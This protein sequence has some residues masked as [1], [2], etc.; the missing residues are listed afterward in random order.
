MEKLTDLSIHHICVLNQYF[1]ALCANH[2]PKE[3]IQIILVLYHKLF[4]IKLYFKKNE[5]ILLFDNKLYDGYVCDYPNLRPVLFYL[6]PIKKVSCQYSH[7]L[8]VATTGNLYVWGK[9]REGQ[10]GLDDTSIFIGNPTKCYL[11]RYYYN[12]NNFEKV[13]N[14]KYHSMAL[15]KSGY[16]YVWGSNAQGQLGRIYLSQRPAQKILQ[17]IKKI[18]CGKFH[19]LALTNQGKVYGWGRNCEGQVGTNTDEK[20]LWTPQKFDLPPIKNIKCGAYHSVAIATSGEIHVWGN[21]D[22][23]QLG[24]KY[25]YDMYYP[26]K[27][28]LP[29]VKKIYC[30]HKHT[31]AITY[32]G[33]T[34]GWGYRMGGAHYL[35]TPQKLDVP[36]MKK[37][38][39]GKN[40]TV[41]ISEMNEI[42]VWSEESTKP[43]KITIS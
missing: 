30:G 40:K 13:R 29:N 1:Q 12:V 35:P 15:T 22:Y 36:R 42:Y 37:I 41:L 18:T 8:A 25:P 2:Y 43:D 32:D 38:I 16:L 27:L 34:Y 11:G 33:F 26:E 21:N 9:N 7:C 28:D 14:G 19:S 23:G 4:K 3:L 10:L 17:N 24:T 6:P 39:C 31:M 20:I 5:F